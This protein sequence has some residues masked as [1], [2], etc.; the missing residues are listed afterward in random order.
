MLAPFPAIM[1]EGHFR[2]IA[3]QFRQGFDGATHTLGPITGEHPMR[4]RVAA[5]VAGILPLHRI[6]IPAQLLFDR[7]KPHHT[8]RPLPG[9]TLG[10]P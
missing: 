4:E 8:R 7:D 9:I 10:V 3:D 2:R 1:I 5:G 6:L